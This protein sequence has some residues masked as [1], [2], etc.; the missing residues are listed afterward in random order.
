MRIPYNH[1]LYYFET[2]LIK[3]ADYTELLRINKSRTAYQNTIQP[4]SDDNEPFAGAFGEVEH[5]N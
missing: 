4:G 3:W 1:K 2:L 5:R